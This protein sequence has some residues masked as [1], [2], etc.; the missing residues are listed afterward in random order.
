MHRDHIACPRIRIAQGVE[1]RQAGAQQRRRFG[2]IERIG[3][4]HQTARFC[5]HAFGIA[6]VG[7]HARD[8]RILAIHDIAL[9]AR[10]TRAVFAGQKAHPYAL[11]HLPAVD[12]VTQRLDTAHDF[13]AGR[14]WMFR[15]RRCPRHRRTVRVADTTG[16]DA[17]ADLPEPRFLDR[18]IDHRQL[19]GRHGYRSAVGSICGH[20]DGLTR[21]GSRRDPRPRSAAR[22]SRDSLA[23]A[24]RCAC[25]WAC[26]CLAP[27]HNH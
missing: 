21:S 1:C 24:D 2:G 19:A 3:N 6:A 18:P 25:A 23:Y 27:R 16:F 8:H 13:M 15:V 5:Q 17:N 7:R 26:V 12:A 9:A 11:A 14:Q 10:R 22:A 20:R 4:T